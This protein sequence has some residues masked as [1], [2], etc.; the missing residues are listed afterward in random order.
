MSDTPAADERLVVI[1][2]RRRLDPSTSAGPRARCWSPDTAAELILQPCAD[3][4]PVA[5]D[6]AHRDAESLRRLLDGE[7]GEVAQLHDAA[8]ALVLALEPGQSFLDRQ[9]LDAL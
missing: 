9:E 2:R 4:A 7:A 1:V 8:L 5:L 6:R 3:E